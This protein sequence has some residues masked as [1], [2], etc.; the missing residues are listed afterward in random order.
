[1]LAFYFYGVM[2]SLRNLMNMTDPLS[3]IICECFRDFVHSFRAFEVPEAE[4]W[5]L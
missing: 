1:M 5:T 2:D 4:A 3:G